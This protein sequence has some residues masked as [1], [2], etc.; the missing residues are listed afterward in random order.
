MR[1][2]STSTPRCR[3]RRVRRGPAGRACGRTAQATTQPDDQAGPATTTAVQ[4][5]LGQA[6]EVPEGDRRARRRRRRGTS[7]GPSRAPAMALTRDAGEHQRDDLGPA[8]G[9]GH[10][11]RRARVVI[12]AADE[13]SARRR[14]SGP[15][16]VSPVTMTGGRADRGAGG[17]ADDAGL[18]QRVAEDALHAARRRSP[19]RR[20]RSAASTT[21]GKRTSHRAFSP[22]AA[23]GQR[24]DVE[25]EPVQQRA[26]HL[27]RGDRRTCPVPAATRHDSEQADG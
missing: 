11:S 20:R 13:G 26:E 9:A 18:G 1:S 10:Q 5:G 16:T 3:A 17:D 15:R 27:G 6:A 2:R 7:A 22:C 25:P 21:R 19:A 8:V 12:E 23:G 4:F 24:A 14:S